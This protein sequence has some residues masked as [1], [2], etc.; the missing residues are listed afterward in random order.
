METGRMSEGP[1]SVGGRLSSSAKAGIP[2]RIAAEF[3]SRSGAVAPPL[4]A[5]DRW[6][7]IKTYQG[8]KGLIRSGPAIPRRRHSGR[9]AG[10][11]H[12][13]ALRVVKDNKVIFRTI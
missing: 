1:P 3:H 13:P 12:G 10:R 11:S 9:V 5:S 4:S 7:F 8:V 2:G 6:Y